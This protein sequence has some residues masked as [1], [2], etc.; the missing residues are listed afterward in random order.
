MLFLLKNEHIQSEV[1]SLFGV[2]ASLLF[3]QYFQAINV[4]VMTLKNVCDEISFIRFTGNQKM[5]FMSWEYAV[6][7][8][9]HFKTYAILFLF[10]LYICVFIQT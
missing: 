1:E 7:L 5:N 10:Y 3:R 2:C 8:Q 4:S 9:N 6:S